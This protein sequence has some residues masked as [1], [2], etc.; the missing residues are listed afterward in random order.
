MVQFRFGAEGLKTL[1]EGLENQ[2]VEEFGAV[3]VE[4]A[5][6]KCVPKLSCHKSIGRQSH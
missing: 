1:E 2:G 4:D 6:L 3:M 5:K